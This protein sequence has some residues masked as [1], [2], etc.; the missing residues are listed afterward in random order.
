MHKYFC[1]LKTEI[2]K[3]IKN[4]IKNKNRNLRGAWVA[5]IVKH[6]PSAQV[7]TSAS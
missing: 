5:H 6:V 1:F 4:S 3:K 2:L 7:M